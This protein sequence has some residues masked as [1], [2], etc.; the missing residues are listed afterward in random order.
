MAVLALLVSMIVAA[1]TVVMAGKETSVVVNIPPVVSGPT[2]EPGT[3]DGCWDT[4]DEHSEAWG[5]DRPIF[6]GDHAPEYPALNSM[7]TTWYGDERAYFNVRDAQIPDDGDWQFRVEVQR[8]HE[9]VLRILVHNAAVAEDLVAENTRL[10]VILPTCTGQSITSVA[11]VHSTNAFPVKSWSSVNF[12]AREQFNLIYVPGTARLES[13]A[14]AGSYL[15]L[16]EGLLLG[17]GLLIGFEE[18]DGRMLPGGGNA[19][20]VTLRVRPQFA[21]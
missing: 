20:W 8:G 12:W 3:S 1:G 10:S 9:Y 6:Q 4:P 5:P 7:I 11:L 15:P 19:V 18:Q 14:Y 17:Q 13:E 16:N 2:M 21:A